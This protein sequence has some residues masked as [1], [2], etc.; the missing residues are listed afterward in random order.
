MEATTR[1]AYT[2]QIGKH[3]LLLTTNAMGCLTGGRHG[4]DGGSWALP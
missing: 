4:W 3:I 2:Y 1:E